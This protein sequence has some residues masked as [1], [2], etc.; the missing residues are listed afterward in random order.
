[1]QAIRVP[2]KLSGGLGIAVRSDF[3]ETVD[4]A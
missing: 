1:M 2:D 3:G 4:E